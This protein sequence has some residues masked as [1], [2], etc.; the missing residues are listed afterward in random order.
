MTASSGCSLAH[1]GRRNA[2]QR[3]H[4]D[5]TAQAFSPIYPGP[6]WQAPRRIEGRGQLAGAG[7]VPL[8]ADVHGQRE[9]PEGTRE[10]FDTAP[11]ACDDHVLAP[12]RLQHH[13][14]HDVPDLQAKPTS[15]CSAERPEEDQL[16]ESR[17][18]RASSNYGAI[19]PHGPRHSAPI[20]DAAG[21]AV[22][23]AEALQ[24]PHRKLELQGGVVQVP[25]PDVL[26]ELG[27]VQESRRAMEADCSTES[28]VGIVYPRGFLT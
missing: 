21:P 10:R 27:Q 16:R 11:Q 28:G 3:P 26:V 7:Q 17:G 23:H 19:G 6:R 15:S 22:Q 8:L 20:Q 24:Q 12:R 14:V 1:T 5:V 18:C 25:P 2:S 4:G 13:V 9:A